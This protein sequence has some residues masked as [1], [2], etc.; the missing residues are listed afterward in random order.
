MKSMKENW[1]AFAEPMKQSLGNLSHIKENI[2]DTVADKMDATKNGTTTEET[3][4]NQPKEKKGCLKKVL[5]YGFVII[6]I[7]AFLKNGCSLNSTIERDNAGEQ[8]TQS[9]SD[10]STENQS[11]YD[12][13]V[14][15]SEDNIAALVAQEPIDTD[16]LEDEYEFLLTCLVSEY[17]FKSMAHGHFT[18]DYETTQYNHIPE[19]CG[20]F[21]GEMKKYIDAEIV[22]SMYTAISVEAYKS[23]DDTMFNYDSCLVGTAETPDIDAMWEIYFDSLVGAVG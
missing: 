12:N 2:S 13:C 8:T 21:T 10:T 22:D 1:E 16:T 6:A 11:L 4:E 20:E 15:M 7:L 23:F 3:S 19:K 18:G 17:M 14:Q 5:V 9:Q